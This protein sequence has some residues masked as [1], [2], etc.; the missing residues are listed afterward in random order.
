MSALVLRHSANILH[1]VKR[2]ACNGGAP[3][4][5]NHAGWT[6]IGCRSFAADATSATGKKEETPTVKQLHVNAEQ[7]DKLKAK[8]DGDVQAGKVVPV[9]KRALHYGNR[10]AIKDEN[11]E[12]SYHQIYSGAKELAAEISQLCGRSYSVIAFVRQHSLYAFISFA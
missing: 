8:F 12:Y 10:I 11:G 9:F 3:V 7:L 2:Y 5:I 1:F 6:Q 4:N